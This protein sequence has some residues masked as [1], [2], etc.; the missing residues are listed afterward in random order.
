MNMKNMIKNIRKNNKLTQQQFA[1]KLGIS[2]NA[3]I[4]YEKGTRKPSVELLLKISEIFNVSM[5]ELTGSAP[6]LSSE[7][8]NNLYNTGLVDNCFILESSSNSIKIETFK[9]LLKTQG[10]PVENILEDELNDLYIKT[11]DYIEYQYSK[12]G[13]IKVDN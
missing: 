8:A 7:E 9:A 12:L 1:K 10:F 11:I 3:L 4:N 13:Y 2:R 6:S 5:N